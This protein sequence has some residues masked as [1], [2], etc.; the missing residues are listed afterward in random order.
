MHQPIFLAHRSI[1]SVTGADA[2]PFLNGIVTVS[3]LDLVEGE[4]HYGAL[5][6]PQ[7]KII[8]DFLVSRQGEDIRPQN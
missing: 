4:F 1:V 8:A 6:T 3:T 5:L 2:E 7:G